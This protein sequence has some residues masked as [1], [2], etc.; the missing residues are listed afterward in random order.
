MEY[1]HGAP[2]WEKMVKDPKTGFYD[3]PLEKW[4]RR[5]QKE[6]KTVEKRQG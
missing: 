6:G 3:L 4:R 1:H 5:A 2:K